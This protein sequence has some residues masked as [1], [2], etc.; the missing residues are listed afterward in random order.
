MI[1]HFNGVT[2]GANIAHKPQM[3]RTLNTTKK[4]RQREGARGSVLVRER[5][6]V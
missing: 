6:G 5:E 3:M 1:R 2:E 4:E